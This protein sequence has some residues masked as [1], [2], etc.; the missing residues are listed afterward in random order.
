MKYVNSYLKKNMI[1]KY[2]KKTEREGWIDMNNMENAKKEF[3]E[4]VETIKK[5]SAENPEFAVK[6]VEA[7]N[8]E[9]LN[10]VIEDEGINTIPEIAQALYQDIRKNE[11]DGELQETDLEE[12][13]GGFI[14]TG[15]ALSVAIWAVCAGGAGALI[16]GVYKGAKAKK[17]ACQ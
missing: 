11:I 1:V 5:Y 2:L 15:Y 7:S 12:V 3:Y 17:N 9:Q 13:S 16:Y 10:K 6:L 8:P 4:T 14:L